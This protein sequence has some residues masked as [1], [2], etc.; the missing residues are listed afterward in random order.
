MMKDDEIS[1]RGDYVG[2]V[3]LL[4]EIAHEAREAG[5]DISQLAQSLSQQVAEG[6]QSP[7]KN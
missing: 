1:A 2:G 5:V 6:R 7:K 3:P 4:A